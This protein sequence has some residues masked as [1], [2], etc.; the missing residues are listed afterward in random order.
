MRGPLPWPH[1]LWSQAQLPSSPHD[2]IFPH[3]R[4]PGTPTQAPESLSPPGC[5]DPGKPHVG[6]PG[7][8]SPFLRGPQLTQ[9]GVPVALSAWLHGP[10]SNSV[11]FPRPWSHLVMGSLSDPLGRD[12]QASIPSSLQAPTV[13]HAGGL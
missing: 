9:V 4:V 5:W 10:H 13:T 2:T 7:H 8:Q 12:P 3:G 6:C 11:G 1:L